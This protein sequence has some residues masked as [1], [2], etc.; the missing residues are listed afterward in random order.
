MYGVRDC[1]EW[2][3]RK[4][5]DYAE[6]SITGWLLGYMSGLSSMY[7]LNG[8]KNNPLKKATSADQINLWMDNYCLKNPLS[9]ISEGG[10]ELF[11]ELIKKQ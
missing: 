3:S 4:K 11:I 1:G 2:I 5:N 10:D 6:L 7:E 8:H 9:N